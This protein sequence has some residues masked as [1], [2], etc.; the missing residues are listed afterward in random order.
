MPEYFII[1][2]FWVRGFKNLLLKEKQIKRKKRSIY[3]NFVT[4][5]FISL[6]LTS[7]V[8]EGVPELGG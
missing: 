4:L 3:F 2:I 1:K 6:A 7:L 5:L 8:I